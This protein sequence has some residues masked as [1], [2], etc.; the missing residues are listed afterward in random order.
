MRA[1]SRALFVP[2]V[3]AVGALVSPTQT[4]R[5]KARPLIVFLD[6]AHNFLNRHIGHEDSL[7]RLD[8]FDQVAKEGRKYLL[9][10]WRPAKP[11]WSGSTRQCRSRFPSTSPSRAGLART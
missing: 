5:G 8:A 7:V 10:R 3:R 11:L 1:V 6:E 2:V 4:R 9:Q